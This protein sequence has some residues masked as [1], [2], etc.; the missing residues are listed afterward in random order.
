MRLSNRFGIPLAAA[1]WICFAN[2]QPGPSYVPC[3]DTMAINSAEVF[4][5]RIADFCT[6]AHCSQENNVI[7]KV[8]EHLK[9]D[10]G[11]RFQF[12]IDAPVATLND[13][14]DRGSRLLIFDH[15]GSDRSWGNLKVKTIDLSARDLKILTADMSVLVDPE[16]ILRAA[17]EAIGRHRNVYGMV[18]FSKSIPA[19]IAGQLGA[20]VWPKTTVPADSELERWA[21]SALDSKVDSERSEAAEAMGYFPS[22]ANAAR[23]RPLIDDPAL[24]NNGY[25]NVNIY[26]VRQSA[27]RS[28]VRMG[29]SVP[30]PV[31]QTESGKP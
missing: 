16:E 18:S 17:K 25:G 23:L 20:N 2:A 3:L 22:E 26:F 9:G 29:V 15:L 7:V 30:K 6:P 27:Y 24:S 31:L 8:E 19:A 10:P 13:W 11:D 4:V 5:V 21:L 14:K 28:L 1:G 12:R